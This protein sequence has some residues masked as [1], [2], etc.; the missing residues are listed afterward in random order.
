MREKLLKYLKGKLVYFRDLVE[1]LFLIDVEGFLEEML[2][3]MR[4]YC[5][6]IFLGIDIFESNIEL[7]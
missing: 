3:E 7:F 6:F 2:F 5:F 4:I 1:I